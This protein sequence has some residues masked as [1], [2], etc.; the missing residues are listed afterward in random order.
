MLTLLSPGWLGLVVAS[1]I[2]AYMSTI[3]THLNWGSSYVV[4]DFYQRFVKPDATEKEL[5]MIGRLSTVGLMIIAGVLAL[6]I[7]ENATQAFNILLLSGAGTGAIFL[8][9]WFWWRINAVTEIVGMIVATINAFVLVLGIS[10]EMLANSYLDAFTMRLLIA[11][12]VTTTVWVL[13]TLLTKPEDEEKLVS[14]VSRVKP[15]IGW[16]RF[17]NRGTPNLG[18]HLLSVFVGTIGIYS[19]LFAIGNLL[20]GNLF[21]A[22]VMFLVFVL[23]V[24]LII[25][26]WKN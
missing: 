10:D 12:G 2:A 8:F 1:L 24:F 5:V 21:L 4:N 11:T 13:T 18:Y 7:L 20:Y 25:K 26:W 17:E 19:A 22:F 23:S 15:G 6:T 9:R 16:N 14:F 3:S